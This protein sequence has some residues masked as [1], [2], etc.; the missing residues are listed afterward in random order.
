MNW[1]F[2]LI[3]IVGTPGAPTSQS[4]TPIGSEEQCIEAGK[5]A[6]EQLNVSTR[7]ICVQGRL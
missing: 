7:F 3:F 4:S 5:K 6:S 1:V 2:Y